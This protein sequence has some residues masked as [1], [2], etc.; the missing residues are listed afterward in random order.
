MAA[1]KTLGLSGNA[2]KLLAAL[3]ML[4]DH[5][6]FML[7]PE[8]RVLRILGRLAFPIFAFMIAEGCR[9]TKN[10][11]RYFLQLFLLGVGCQ[12]VNYI[13]QKDTLLC[14]LITFSVSILLIYLLQTVK[15]V[16][17]SPRPAWQKI[18]MVL[19]FAAAVAAVWGLNRIFRIDYGFIGCMTPVIA[20]AFMNREREG[21]PEW[22]LRLD[23]R[24]V[25]VLMLGLA[26]LL[27]ALFRSRIQFWALFALIPLF[28]Y[29]GR[30]GRWRM[31]YFFYIFYPAHLAALYGVSLF[32]G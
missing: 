27:M 2:L 1:E 31:K 17:F 12:I 11:T 21:V 25:H 23:R 26:L 30:R 18:G 15:R 14:I 19:L 28:A 8:L 4:I 29:S 7:L 20:G 24:S 10:R 32:L 13:A 6:G 5:I 3:S 9:Y 16:C 22:L